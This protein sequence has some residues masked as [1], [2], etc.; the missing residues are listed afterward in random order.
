MAQKALILED[1]PANLQ[2]FERLFS[3]AGFDIIPA[4]T[5]K[6]ALEQLNNQTDI[7]LAVLDMEVPDCTGIEMTHILRQRYP[8]MCIVVATMHDSRTMMQDAFDVGCDVFLV[9][10]HG[11]MELFKR[12]TTDGSHVLH[13]NRPIIIDQFGPRAFQTVRS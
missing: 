1:T 4:T 13:A 6:Q 8:D 10:P 5:G 2:F 11:F 9:K 7:T 3:Q 12:L